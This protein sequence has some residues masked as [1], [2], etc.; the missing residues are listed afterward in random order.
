[1]TSAVPVLLLLLLLGGGVGWA[2][3][4]WKG[5]PV[6]GVVTGFALGPLGWIL[7]LMYPSQRGERLQPGGANS[8]DR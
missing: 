1:M 8:V 3:G 2:L 4:T 7:M 5:K 6:L